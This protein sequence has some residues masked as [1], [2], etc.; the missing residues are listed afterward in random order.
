M[1]RTAGVSGV[2]FIP[3]YYIR[4]GYSQE[5]EC[6]RVC[7]KCLIWHSH[8]GTEPA[9][10][11]PQAMKTFCVPSHKSICASP[12][13][14]QGVQLQQDMLGNGIWY[15]IG[16][17]SVLRDNE[18]RTEYILRR[19]ENHDEYAAA[20]KAL[21]TIYNDHSELT[22]VVSMRWCSLTYRLVT[23]KRVWLG[24]YQ[25]EKNILTYSHMRDGY[26]LYCFCGFWEN[27]E[28]SPEV[29]GTRLRRAVRSAL[30][31]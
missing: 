9:V 15:A 1:W 26:P 30:H 31:Q 12:L 14:E 18:H 4:G 2:F 11:G 6:N 19:S 8:R 16:G 7:G 3:P 24:I 20:L 23:A 22:A 25:G 17:E 5:F 27:P 29:W 28:K 13:S 10:R 21:L